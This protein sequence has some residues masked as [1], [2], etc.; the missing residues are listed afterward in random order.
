MISFKQ[1][2]LEAKRKPKEPDWPDAD[3]SSGYATLRDMQNHLSEKHHDLQLFVPKHRDPK[4]E[5]QR[6]RDRRDW[7][8]R[9]EIEAEES[10][11]LKEDRT[12]HPPI[13]SA[14]RESPVKGNNKPSGAFWTSSARKKSNGEYTSEWYEHV[15]V[16]FRE[17]QTDYGYLF[18]V[19][20][21]AMVLNTGYL[22]QYYDWAETHGRAE[23]NKEY[24]K[25]Y[26]RST[27]MRGNFPWKELAK[28]FDGV[29]HSGYSRHD[30]D[31]FTY[32]WDVESTAW[33]NTSVLEYK[34]A[35]RLWHGFDDED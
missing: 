2:I 30:S 18:A 13:L 23:E 29:H 9:K 20:P 3:H 6:K 19:K 32:G 24:F 26:G 12:D 1:F 34:G 25:S 14:F 17:W 15:K 22:E 5:L 33:L 27:A 11:K 35:V 8:V 28:H 7:E 4:L 16:N 10:K 21:G 31:D